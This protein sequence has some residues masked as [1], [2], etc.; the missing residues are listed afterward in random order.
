[1]SLSIPIQKKITL[2]LLPKNL[3]PN[4]NLNSKNIRVACTKTK[5]IALITSATLK[6]KIIFEHISATAQL[7]LATHKRRYQLSFFL[8]F[9][10]YF[11]IRDTHF[12]RVYLSLK[13]VTYFLH[14]RHRWYFHEL[15]ISI[16]HVYNI[17]HLFW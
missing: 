8:L 2:Y 11:Y 17:G 4:A 6:T 5:N 15:R 10:L 14:A 16:I 13:D 12:L 9:L 7:T 3:E 1:M